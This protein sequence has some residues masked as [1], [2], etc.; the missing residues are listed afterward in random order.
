M[1]AEREVGP[2]ALS[3]PRVL[4]VLRRDH[5]PAVRGVL[6]L[7]ALVRLA[8]SFWNVEGNSVGT[9]SLG[10]GPRR[11]PVGQ[12]VG[13]PFELDAAE[14][15]GEAHVVH[16]VRRVWLLAG[17]RL[18]ADGQLPGARLEQLAGT[19]VVARRQQERVVA[20]RVGRVGQR[21]RLHQEQVLDDGRHG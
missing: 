4:D 17:V 16:L 2:L 10:I 12:Q 14:G 9:V 19:R 5:L 8:G 6:V 20:G 18:A 3:R 13:R 21:G 7:L 11:L 15:R 1:P